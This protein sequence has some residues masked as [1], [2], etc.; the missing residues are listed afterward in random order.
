MSG[1]L[2]SFRKYVRGSD[3]Y[4]SV[5]YISYICYSRKKQSTYFGYWLYFGY[6]YYVPEE[7]YYVLESFCQNV[8]EVS[9]CLIY[10]YIYIYIYAT[11][12]NLH[13]NVQFTHIY[14]FTIYIYLYMLYACIICMLVS[15]RKWLQNICRQ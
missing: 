12:I 7:G 1:S 5:I 11:H 14:L 8:E 6:R 15:L 9:R 4:I 3:I 2:E 10:I 13:L